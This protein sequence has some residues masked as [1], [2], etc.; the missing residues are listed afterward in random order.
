M[1]GDTKP[2]CSCGEHVIAVCGG[3]HN[4]VCK[5]LAEAAGFN[6]S[7]GAVVARPAACAALAPGAVAAAA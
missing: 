2:P 3:T 5:R 1:L 7:G 6:A 4:A